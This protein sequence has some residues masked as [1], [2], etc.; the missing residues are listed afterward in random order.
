MALRG[1]K[2]VGDWVIDAEIAT[3]G[4]TTRA[5]EEQRRTAAPA[6]TGRVRKW[7]KRWG[8]TDHMTLLRWER[9][10]EEAV[11]AAPS[12]NLTSNHEPPKADPETSNVKC[13]T[14][15]TTSNGLDSRWDQQRDGD[16][17]TD[18]SWAKRQ[19]GEAVEPG[20]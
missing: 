9:R 18:E 16:E 6:F 12:E 15:G 20:T 1:V 7:E 19:K 2:A 14:P 5:K 13:E 8:L 17:V 3:R 4:Y 11:E 10:E